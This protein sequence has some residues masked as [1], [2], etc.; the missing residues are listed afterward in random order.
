[1]PIQVRSEIAPLRRVLLHRPGMELEH[2]NPGSLERLLFDDI[3]YLYGARE[4]HDRFAETLRENGAKVEYLAD[5]AA[6][7]LTANPDLRQAFVSRF[8][9][10]A[11]SAASSYKPA[12]TRFLLD[13]P[14]DQDLILRTMAGVKLD[15]ISVS[16]NHSLANLLRSE[17]HFV[18]DPIP[19]LYFTRDPFACIGSGVAINRM[20]SVTRARETIY[21]D[22]IF[23]HHPAFRG[24]VPFYYLP[25]EAFSLEGGDVLNLSAKVLAVGVSQRTKPEAVEKLA[26][27]ILDDPHAEIATVL[28]LEI[29]NMRAFMHLD[30]VLTQIDIDKFI[31]H[32]EILHTLRIF[33]LCAKGDGVAAR[34]LNTPLSETLCHY[35][36]L[37]HVEM[38]HCGGQDRIAAEREQWND[39][40]NTLCISPG[41]VIAYDRNHIT[42]R[43]LEDKGVRVLKI[44]SAELSRG[45][46]GPRCMSMPL[47][48]D[49]L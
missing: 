12:L 44:P 49:K 35:L 14:S 28:A 18:L 1:M 27:N 19:N 21:G 5:L 41:V 20:Y 11:G 25:S 6:E 40:S 46:G 38:I 3:P 17:A 9:D 30:T 48:R 37:E 24:R 43:M 31:V 45:R 4:E 16:R 29:P 39:G 32:P 10:S 47:W 36:G 7:T 15:E 33:E 2:L 34:E 22:M 26:R 42:N 13:I 8:I 23:H